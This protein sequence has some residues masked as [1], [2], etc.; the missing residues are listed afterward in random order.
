MFN[1]VSQLE[2]IICRMDKGLLFALLSLIEGTIFWA[3]IY[4]GPTISLSPLYLFPIILSA[5]F[6]DRKL[7]YL[8]VVFSTAARIY[9]LSIQ[10]AEYIEF[11]LVLNT[12][13]TFLAYSAFAELALQLRKLTNK[14]KNHLEKLVSISRH[15]QSKRRI[16]A[17]IRR[18]LPKDTYDIARLV[19]EG[20]INGDLPPELATN[21]NIVVEAF[22]KAILE[23]V[24][25][26]VF[27]GN[28]Q[29]SVQCDIWVSVVNESPVGLIVV[30]ANK[31][32]E[33]LER[34]LDIISVSRNYRQLGIG[35]ALVNL[36]CS[37]Y[38]GRRLIVACKDGSIMMAMAKRRG[39]KMYRDS[40]SGYILMHKLP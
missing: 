24:C 6:L 27:S 30:V 39:F 17:T 37:N 5:W 1:I 28:E 7:S 40:S 32:K 35:T 21:Q 38:R 11:P 36:F 2:N 16:A 10:L 15:I 31:D 23:G 14:Y 25:T 19:A 3:D 9:N 4:N 34:E 29:L 26:R 8:F 18:A 13:I 33:H 12:A 20:A 22:K